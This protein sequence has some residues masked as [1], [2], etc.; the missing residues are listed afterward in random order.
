MK[1]KRLFFVLLFFCTFFVSFSQSVNNARFET[2]G[3]TIRIF[4]DLSSEA[5]VA[6]YLSMDGGRS[7]SNQPLVQVSGDVGVGVKPGHDRCAVWNVLQERDNLVG[8]NIRF[9]VVA[10]PV[11]SNSLFT[12]G[13]VSFTMV[14]VKEGTFTMGCDGGGNC[15][16]DESPSHKVT[17]SSYHIGETEVTQA[18][19][20]A[21]MGSEPTERGGWESKLGKGDDYPVYRVSYDDVMTFIAKLNQKTGRV[22]RLPT[23]AE[24]EYAAR[25]GNE[26]QGYACSGTGLGNLSE[27]AW[28]VNNSFGKL[29]PVKTKKPNELGLY[30][31]SGNVSEWCS[32][33]YTYYVE[34]AQTNP[35]GPKRGSSH[36]DRGGSWNSKGKDCRVTSR[37]RCEASLCSG[38]LGFRLALSVQ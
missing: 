33:R 4:Y 10:S 6:I 36:V 34:E 28:Y 24:W 2:I 5:N 13:G 16:R 7:Y 37:D 19:W 1:M 8:E 3:E 22:F 32:D 31:M 15:G 27:Y 30:D 26:S 18:L 29:H 25:G 14:Y 9:K 12:V 23:E 38:V 21:V 35:S 17:L 11:E 20:R